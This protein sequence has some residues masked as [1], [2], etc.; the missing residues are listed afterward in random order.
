MTIIYTVASIEKRD[1]EASD[2]AKEAEKIDERQREAEA[3]NNAFENLNSKID[4]VQNEYKTLRTWLSLADAM[5][6]EYDTDAVEQL[7]RNMANDLRTI[8]GNDFDGF[9]NDQE[10]RDLENNFSDYSTE[11]GDRQN[12]I[13]DQIVGHCDDLLDE[14]ATR[15]TVLRI[16]DVGSQEDKQV[17]KE[18]Q[19]FL[20]KHKNG[21][22]QERPG[23]RYQELA[24]QYDDIDIS[25]D[26]VKQ[27]YE[28]GDD[29]MTE[30]KKLLNNKQV[31]LAKID[32][33]VLNDLKNLTQFSQLL[34]IQFK[35]DK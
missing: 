30:L 16:P 10:I 33:E 28:I 12:K 4:E 20:Q 25:F 6:I 8:T 3:K 22:L 18:F 29:A 17:I 34:T 14:L 24:E 19:Q 13:Q 26:A 35:G 2:L 21:D 15:L 23:L 11:L 7:M 27:E 32:E 31:T 5:D 9:E 1:R